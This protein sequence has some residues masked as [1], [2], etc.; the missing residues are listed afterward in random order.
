M[1]TLTAIALNLVGSMGVFSITMLAFG[2]AVKSQNT[3][4]AARCAARPPT[5]IYNPNPRHPCQERGNPTLGW[6]LWVMRLTYDTMLRG[7]PGTG[8]RDGGLS[9]AL[10]KVNLDGIVLLRF[11]HLCL[12]VCSLACFL[13]LVVVLPIYATTQ[14][15]RIGGDFDSSRCEG[16][17]Y[18]LTDYQQLTLAN[19]PS[20]SPPTPENFGDVLSNWFVPGYDGHLAR[21]Y[22]VVFVTWIVTYYA[23]RELKME[24]GD[25]LAMRRVYYLEADHWQ[26]RN[27]EMEQILRRY[28][29]ENS[30]NPD[31][32]E[33]E[34]YLTD[35]KPWIPHPE[36]RD[37]VPN[38]ELY[39]VLVGGLPS[40]PTEVVDQEEV[41]AVFSRKQSIDWQLSVTTAFFD[42]CVPNQPGFSSSIA[43]VTI[44]PS[45]AHLTDAWNQW[46][47]VAGKLR[48]LR[49]IRN[50]IN[51]RK[52]AALKKRADSEKG[53]G[54]ATTSQEQ[55]YLSSL[56]STW[57]TKVHPRS[58]TKH[59]HHDH[60]VLGSTDDLQVESRLLCALD[61][62]PE[63]TAAYSREFALGAANL[64]PYGWHEERILNAS[65][66]DLLMMEKAAVEQ[67][68][69]ANAALREAQERIAE[70]SEYDS[71][72]DMS[73][74]QLHAMMKNATAH[75]TPGTGR[76]SSQETRTISTSIDEEEGC[77]RKSVGPPTSNSTAD[78][79]R[80]RTPSKKLSRSENGT[81]SFESFASLRDDLESIDDSSGR[82]SFQIDLKGKDDNEVSH[83]YTPSKIRMRDNRTNRSMSM[84]STYSSMS[85]ESGNNRRSTL[86]QGV[87]DLG[88]T[89]MKMTG[90]VRTS[91]S[92]SF[93]K[94]SK[95]KKRASK[96]N[97]KSARLPSDLGL[98]A[99][100]WMEHKSMTKNN[101]SVPTPGKRPTGPRR[102]K[103]ALSA[104]MHGIHGSQ[105]ADENTRS[106][107]KRANSSED[108]DQMEMAAAYDH[109]SPSTRR[110]GSRNISFAADSNDIPPESSESFAN[111]SGL[112]PSVHLDGEATNHADSIWTRLEKDNERKVKL[113][114]RL[115][116]MQCVGSNSG[117]TQSEGSNDFG[118]L[119]VD[120]DDDVP[121]AV[122]TTITGESDE[123]KHLIH[124][125][126]KSFA[127]SARR[128]AQQVNDMGACEAAP[129]ELERVAP[130]MNDPINHQRLVGEAIPHARYPTKMKPLDENETDDDD[131]VDMDALAAAARAYG[132][133]PD[134][135]ADSHRS[136][137]SR[138]FEDNLRI[139]F[140]FEEKAG[141][142][143][144]D[145]Y[146]V[147]DVEKQNIDVEDKWAR[148]MAIV[149]ESSRDKGVNYETKERLISSGRWRIPTC[150]GIMDALRKKVKS[151]W[152]FYKLRIKPPDIV[153]DL[154]R[155][156]SYAVVT[157]TSRQ[158]AVAARHCLTDSR[159]HDRWVAIAEIPSPPLADAPVCNMSSF[160]G[161]VR[162][163]TLS[164]SDKQKM[165]RHTL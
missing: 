21:L 37:T 112:N 10:L 114:N 120:D 40:L 6:I 1:S 44:L 57:P 45:A 80:A 143:H 20:L 92:E 90:L 91:S 78:N 8:T 135:A 55:T 18:N 132:G 50:E 47:R 116:D 95:G 81:N 97:M 63:Q 73:E 152:K 145:L 164:I 144:R 59:H 142:R 140:D 147:N 85:N 130:T 107:P 151:I 60:A 46:Y 7:V 105:F 23:L 136:I 99:G 48:R 161:C 67:V 121:I 66:E 146:C 119:G 110:L 127:G 98:E 41:E 84:S 9:G 74:D 115:S 131:S 123:P 149:H 17:S 54:P 28:E 22:A 14:C 70:D 34:S 129:V 11:H 102:K 155:D 13:Y 160:R 61:F 15:S 153:D 38:I 133:D 88:M 33:D 157:F 162:P 103:S 39:S 128:D 3:F 30:G 126:S 100:L 96:A 75:S 56:A 104:S 27:D 83:S 108:I 137:S 77:S 16:R 159:G 35:R 53:G 4:I 89:V 32:K 141:L 64:A 12:R 5:V 124:E 79:Q 158:A 31:V 62:G 29:Q 125:Q 68:H 43:A 117:D 87:G 156:S 138:Q 154:V 24:W 163:V 113:R 106:T 111:P 122:S 76:L 25:V 86:L 65:L 72:G 52:R 134:Y 93:D 58:E 94:L 26:D 71:V 148:V 36:Q 19:I 139:A 165:I 150:A 82:S 2:C 101:G 118:L 69:E 51:K 49:F 109:P 42:H